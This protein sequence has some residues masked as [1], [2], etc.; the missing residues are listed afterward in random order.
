MSLALAT[1]LTRPAETSELHTRILKCA[2]A[3]DESRAYWS[4][5]DAPA[6]AGAPPLTQAAFEGYWFGA[7]SQRATEILLANMRVRFDAFPAALEV[8]HQWTD[9]P[10]EVRQLVCHWHLQL[11][12]PLYRDF[13]GTFLAERRDR[14][15]PEVYRHDVIGWVTE[16]ADGRWTPST[17][18][19]FA[20]KLLSAAL[21][22]GLVKGRRDP[23]ALVYPRVP[24]EALAY[25]LYLLRDTDIQG[26]LTDNPYLASVGLQGGQLADRLR[27]LSSI[28]FRQVG[29]VHDFEWRYPDLTAWA[30]AEVLPR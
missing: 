13:T 15:R 22:A 9:M 6:P 10:P 8:L 27:A 14:L 5:R 24:D 21:S 19:Q 25:L 4:H 20:S 16:L 29:D 1:A 3:V 30:R 18:T 2:L 23:R 11:A 17:R 26:P 7:R 28:T 12:D